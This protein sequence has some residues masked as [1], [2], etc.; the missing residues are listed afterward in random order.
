MTATAQTRTE[1]EGAPLAD[2][3][4]RG[5]RRW[6]ARYHWVIALASYTLLT[7][8]ITFPIIFEMGDH[9]LGV[10]STGD[11]LWNAWYPWWFRRAILSGQ[12]PTYTHMIYALAPRVQLFAP[13]WLNG[14]VGAVLLTF[15]NPLATYNLLMLIGFPL[16]G[17]TM[18]L[19]TGEF[20]RNRLA[21]FVSG[22][23]FTFS[24]DHFWRAEGHLTLATLEWLP[25]LAW[26]AFVFYRRPTRGNAIWLG[27]AAAL[28]PLC[29]FYLTA[30]FLVPFV[31]VFVV[32]L[33]I[34]DRGWFAQWRHLLL[35]GLAVLVTLVVAL[36]PLYSSLRVDPSMQ[37]AINAYAQGGT[38]LYS[39]DLLA[40][41]LPHPANPWLGH[42]GAQIYLRMTSGPTIEQSN[43]LGWVT[44]LL[45]MGAFLFVRN[46]TR[47]T[48][49]WLVLAALGGLISL[50][51]VV[52]IAGHGYARVPNLVFDLLYR[53][54]VLSN[55]RAPN[56]AAPTVGLPLALLAGV[57]LDSVF[58][59]LRRVDVVLRAPR[60][61]SAV[62]YSRVAYGA[63]CVVA[64]GLSLFENTQ[65]SL[66]YPSAAVHVPELYYEMAHDPTPGLVLMLP[67]YPRGSDHYYQII[68]Q[69]ALVDGYP[70]RTSV[71]MLRSIEN[72]PYLS[73]FDPVDEAV[74][75][76]ANMPQDGGFGDIYPI[77]VSFK[78][79]LE[80]HGIRYVVY[81]A[82]DATLV[83][84]WMPQFLRQRLGTPFYDNPAESLLAWRLDPMPPAAG[85][86][87][88]TMGDGWLVGLGA[89]TDHVLMRSVQQNG[90]LLIDAPHAGPAH[91]ELTAFAQLL[92][93]TLVLSLNGH[94]ILTRRFPQAFQQ[95][96]L[97]LGMLPLKAGTNVLLI[98]SVEGCSIPEQVVPGSGDPR[99][100]SFSIMNVRMLPS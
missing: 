18:Y 39:A 54:P 67:I 25:L 23:L 34:T 79:G 42:I 80:E 68:H 10:T 77:T 73:Y 33:L 19:L 60:W 99:C 30:Y 35:A 56:R 78:Q 61:L 96:T 70:I 94:T 12:D 50:G 47:V 57:T 76:D 22:F 72:V 82:Q 86:Y 1:I 69:R 83:Q 2:R 27:L 53:L 48:L 44:I 24:T 36:P 75:R 5:W 93:K 85:V 31:L 32:W 51:P 62:P 95:Q 20:V 89:T 59:R 90:Q 4:T 6:A 40:Y 66:P 100:F 92:P 16:S 74:A 49:F 26:R 88:F 11:N 17:L 97:D 15:F 71:P 64:M 55:F 37:S 9:V 43:Y 87:R 28:G 91:L 84:P 7:L 8:A 3:E 45:G 41:F 29:D 21:C 58:A 63:L 38:E 52:H 81:T 14:A 13:T 98:H 46:R 65:F